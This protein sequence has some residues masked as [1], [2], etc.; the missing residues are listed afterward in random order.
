MR[1]LLLGDLLLLV[2]LPLSVSAAGTNASVSVEG[3]VIGNQFSIDV[4]APQT[5][6]T[7]AYGENE[8]GQPAGT[9][10]PLGLPIANPL[11]VTAHATEGIPFSVSVSD[12]LDWGKP[13]ASK[14]KMAQWNY[15]WTY[16]DFPPPGGVAPLCPTGGPGVPG[17]CTIQKNQWMPSGKVL[18]KPLV[19]NETICPTAPA[20]PCPPG[21][22]V[23]KNYNMT[24]A[25][26]VLF[27]GIGDTPPS[28]PPLAGT[29]RMYAVR[30]F[31]TLDDTSLRYDN[32]VG[33]PGPSP[34]LAMVQQ[35]T[36]K[37]PITFTLTTL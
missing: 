10:T 3:G 23:S 5:G 6:F 35:N 34:Q 7:M 12:K 14:G 27:T 20:V 8:W 30:Q 33:L 24:L 37:M 9:I 25:D 32:P 19:L 36:Y 11:T 1:K 21:P 16:T 13:V 17:N 15:C 22:F 4:M 18:T 26:P 2:L 31:I 28:G 29:S